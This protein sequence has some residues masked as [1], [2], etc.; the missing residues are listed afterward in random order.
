MNIDTTDKSLLARWS[1]FP[2]LYR[3]TT[4]FM[5][6]AGIFILIRLAIGLGPTTNM[7]DGYPWGIWIVY[8]VVVGTA[9]GTGGFLMAI[10]I[11]L[12]N[13]WE[14]HPLI[15]SAIMT[16]AFGYTI[17]GISVI[18]DLG[19]WFNFYS[20]LMPWRY[21]THSVLL[22]VALCIMG[23]TL[24]TWIELFPAF[25]EKKDQYKFMQF[26]PLRKAAEFIAN[27]PKKWNRILVGVISL[28]ILLP[29]MHQSSLGSMM[30][31]AGNKVHPLWQAG[32]QPILFLFSVAFM[33]YSMVVVEAF[34]ARN[35]FNVPCECDMIRKLVPTVASIA[36]LWIVMR[37]SSLYFE[38]K[39]HLIFTSGMYSITF[40]LETAMVLMGTYMLVRYRY[41][42]KPKRIFVAAFLLVFAGAL[43]RFNVYL[44]AYDPGQGY[45]YFPS[46]METAITF[47]FVAA[48]LTLYFVFIRSF[49]ILH[50]E[51]K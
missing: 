26:A 21:N 24:V 45:T 51:K 10:V 32:F 42:G 35:F 23:Y 12:F 50:N 19:R 49:S 11:Y 18:I 20:L 9:L 29:V 13:K 7:N 22:E 8:D 47:G 16:S 36:T 27:N 33:G 46:V 38:E 40:F 5:L 43:Y 34:A 31:I 41:A 44:I 25:V 6:L 37:F 14:Y 2:L 48:E 1:Q 39:Y 30:V 3:M 15:R 4:M 28:G 17:A